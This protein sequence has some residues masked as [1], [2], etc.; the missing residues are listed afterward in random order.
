MKILFPRLKPAATKIF[1]NKMPNTLAVN[2]EFIKSNRGFTLIEVII[3]ILVMGIIGVTVLIS[4][5]TVLRGGS[6][7]KQKTV[8]LQTASQCM[9]WYLNQRHLN[10]F[11]AIPCPSTTVPSFCTPPSGYTISTNISCTQLYG[12]TGANYKTITVTA[13]SSGTNT[14]S[15]SLLLANY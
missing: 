1:Y 15:L 10:G 13:S 11:S 14:A 8:A 5:D 4:M 3:F 6:T 2:P 12:E 9:E 7:S